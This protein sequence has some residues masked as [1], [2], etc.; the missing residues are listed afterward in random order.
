MIDSTQSAKPSVMGY[1]LPDYRV[2]VKAKTIQ[3]E[4]I[5]NTHGSILSEPWYESDDHVTRQGCE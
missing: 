1:R 2:G 5:G 4:R 3:I